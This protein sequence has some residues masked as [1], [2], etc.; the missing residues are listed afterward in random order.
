[1]HDFFEELG[2]EWDR[3]KL[4]AIGGTIAS[5]ILLVFAI[6][7]LIIDLRILRFRRSFFDLLDVSFS[8][9][10]VA[11]LGYF[12][13]SLLRQYLFFKRWQERLGRLRVLEEELLGEE[14]PGTANQ[15]SS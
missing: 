10:A 12:A 13:Y 7:L 9:I 4:G 14:K 1:M 8:L 11:C 6:R 5:G 2:R 3:F 15:N